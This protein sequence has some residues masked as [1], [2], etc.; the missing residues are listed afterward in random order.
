MVTGG[1]NLGRIGVITNRER[2]PGS[3]DVVHVKDA[4]G[5]SFATR[6]SNIFVIG[7]VSEHG[8][9]VS[10]ASPVLGGCGL[11]PGVVGV[12]CRLLLPTLGAH[13]VKL[14]L[15]SRG[16]D[17]FRLTALGRE[18][19]NKLRRGGGVFRREPRGMWEKEADGTQQLPRGLLLGECHRRHVH[20]AWL[21]QGLALA[22][23]CASRCD[24]ASPSPQGNKP[25]ISLPRGKGIRLTI[26]EE[27]DKRLAAKQSSG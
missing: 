3:F 9:K 11:A 27:R 6:L 15:C 5:N 4:N 2:H 7:K 14:Q 21:G 20:V 18:S 19:G 12:T 25:W 13:R 1:A 16:S 22:A 8:P 23:V 26:A 10:G 24:V 17:S